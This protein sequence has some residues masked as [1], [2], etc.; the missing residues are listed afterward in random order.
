MRIAVI[1]LGTNTFN[2]LVA[3]SR[4]GADFQTLYN[5]KLPV[6]LGEGG[7]NKG[8]ITEAAFQRGIEAMENYASTIRQWHAERTLAF[9]TSAVR[10]AS[11]GKEFVDEVKRRTG[12]EIQVIDGA[13]EAEF[14]SIGVRQAVRLSEKPSLIIDIGGGSTEFIIVDDKSV[15]WKQSFEIGASRLM[16]RFEPSDPVN[17][18]EKK[19]IVDY[20][21]HELKPLWEA[22]KK[23]NVTELIGASGSF[24]SLAEL[25]NMRF[26]SLPGLSNKTEC[27]FNLDQCAIIHAAILSSTRAERLKMKGLVAMRVDLIVVS[28][29]L[30]ETVLNELSISKMRYS[31]YSLKE[32]VLWDFLNN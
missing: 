25:V 29:I 12:I 5:E 2:L 24:E 17:A 7:I 21:I 31:S 10:N 6:K 15:L 3:E 11:N 22:S 27:E 20:L 13:K 23:F 26:H 30:V 9:A 28:A 32:G 19:V 18:D 1:D 4:V 16:Q 8:F 14:I